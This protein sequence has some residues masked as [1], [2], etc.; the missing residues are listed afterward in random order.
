MAAV[1]AMPSSAVPAAFATG[2]TVAVL[3]ADRITGRLCSRA[4][5]PVGVPLAQHQFT[6]FRGRLD[7]RRE[8]RTTPFLAP[9]ITPGL[10]RVDQH[11]VPQSGAQVRHRPLL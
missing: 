4:G 3:V 8:L 1:S 6:V 9:R 11:P 5:E 7:G 10:R 2:E